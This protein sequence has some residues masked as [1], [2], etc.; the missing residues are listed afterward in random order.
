MAQ[1]FEFEYVTS[2]VSLR[3]GDGIV[4]HIVNDSAVDEGDQ[5][6]IFQG[7]GAGA[8]TVVDTGVTSVPPN[9]TGGLGFAISASGEYWVR[10]KVSSE[11]LIPKVSFEQLRNS[12]FVPVVTYRPGD[13]AIF[14]ITDRER[15]W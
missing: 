5:V 1:Q 11:N 6:L 4:V 2:A 8:N 15:I 9:F 13:F 3:D 12:E 14:R 7:T 10:I